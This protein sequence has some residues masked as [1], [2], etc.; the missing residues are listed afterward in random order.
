MKSKILLFSLTLIILASLLTSCMGGGTSVASSWPGLTANGGLAYLAFGQHIYAID[1]ANGSEKWRYPASTEKGVEFYASPA[2]SSDGQ[3]IVGGFNHKIYS[4][5]PANGTQKWVFEGAKDR[6]IAGPLVTENG[7]YAPSTDGSLYALDLNGK[8]KWTFKTQE[9]LWATP[10]TNTECDCIY[11]ASMDRH[12]YAVDAET[13]R[14]IW[15]SSDLGGSIIGTPAYDP[16]N[17]F[18]FVGTFGSEMIALNA[19][20]GQVAWRVPTH[21]WVW[22]GP[23]LVDGV[24]YFG[25]EIGY[26]YALSAVDGV[27]VWKIQPLPNSP[28]V[29]TPIFGDGIIYFTSESASVYGINSD[30]TVARTHN[31]AAK[32]YTPPVWA[33]GNILVAEM[34]GD[35]LVVALNENGAQQWVFTPAK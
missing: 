23:L 6:Y 5:D 15:Q 8:L 25:D 7:I 27:Q 22:S 10:T 18:V 28:I 21:E 24:L 16:E 32:L 35:A 12:V 17:K 30:G 34:E 29:G 19:D 9:A 20:T 13:G 3:L 26:F 1:Q 2:L 14:Q 11:V 4:L 33:N 31:V